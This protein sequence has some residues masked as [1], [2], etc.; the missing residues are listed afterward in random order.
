MVEIDLSRLSI[1]FTTNNYVVSRGVGNNLNT[2]TVDDLNYLYLQLNLSCKDISEL[3]GCCVSAVRTLIRK[4]N[5]VKTKSA[6][7]K[8]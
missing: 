1:D 7:S 4:Y 5:L 6:Y 8:C 3:L 2:P